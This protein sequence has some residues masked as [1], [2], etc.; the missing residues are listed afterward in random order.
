M[1]D[2][3]LPDT[4]IVAYANTLLMFDKEKAG[5]EVEDVVVPE[6]WFKKYYPNG[7]MSR[8][9]LSAKAANG[10]S[11][12]ECYVA[13]LNPTDEDDDLVADITFENGV[14]KVSIAN[15]EKSNRMYRIL[16]T[17]TLDNAES[18]LDVTNVPDLSAQPYNVYRF[19][20]ISAELP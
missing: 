13:G 17:K 14:P 9:A 11:V 3:A 5:M 15:G 2:V 18:P 4:A 7:T 20:R 8:T 16:A 19:F 10:R 12:W 6:R 1:Y